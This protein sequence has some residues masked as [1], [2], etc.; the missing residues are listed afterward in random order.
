MKKEPL[1]FSEDVMEYL[2]GYNWPG[3]VRELRNMIEGLVVLTKDNVVKPVDLPERLLQTFAGD[4]GNF[5]ERNN[6]RTING[7]TS[8][9]MDI[10]EEGIDLEQILYTAERDL[11]NKALK[12]AGGKKSK[13]AK[14]L[15]MNRTTLIEKLKRMG[16]K[17]E[18]NDS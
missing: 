6:N 14:L 17:L 5:V 9:S 8:R 1:V 13:A 12:K 4:S 7:F 16:V 2:L 10:P 18:S 3:N 15:H 11:I